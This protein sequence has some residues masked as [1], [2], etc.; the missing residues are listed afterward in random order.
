[1][2]PNRKPPGP[3]VTSIKL[4]DVYYA[5]F[6][7]KWVILGFFAAGL[8]AAVFLFFTSKPI[9][10]SNASL[11]VRYVSDTKSMEEV[12]DGSRVNSPDRSGRN[13]MN[14]ELEILTSFDVA[15]KAAEN[16]GTEKILGKGAGAASS[17]AAAAI[18]VKNLRIEVPRLS[19]IIKISFA[20]ADP[21]VAQKVLDELIKSYLDRHLQIHLEVGMHNDF[22]TKQRDRFKGEV[23]TAEAQIDSLRLKIGG[24]SIADAKKTCSQQFSMLQQE[25][26]N[27]DVELKQRLGLQEKQGSKPPTNSLPT[28]PPAGTDQLARYRNVVNRLALLRNKELEQQLELTE[29]NSILA[30]T[31][32]Q[33]AETQALKTKMESENPSLTT[34]SE[35]LSGVRTGPAGTMDQ[36]PVRSRFDGT[37]QRAQ[38]T[39]GPACRKASQVGR[40]GHPD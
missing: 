16:V 5:L 30:Q 33:I 6:R 2:T 24:L 31:R 13:I 9:Y 4:D 29:T 3:P 39:V 10:R 20:H 7:R 40:V 21:E 36:V 11:F 12:G 19:N 38:R 18:I 26:M 34:Q 35:P 27:A 8:L 28:T 25:L 22:L 32:Q 1:M 14:S 37:D 17:A 15:Q 23:A